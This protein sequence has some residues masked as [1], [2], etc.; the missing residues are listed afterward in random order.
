MID[1]LADDFLC[2]ADL[3]LARR[4]N[5]V[6][7]IGKRGVPFKAR[8]KGFFA[9]RSLLKPGLICAEDAHHLFLQQKTL[10]L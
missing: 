6:V 7:V 10:A 8:T 5:N 2:L 4:S 3:S 9:M 1:Q